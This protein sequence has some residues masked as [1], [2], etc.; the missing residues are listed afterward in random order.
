MNI[1]KHFYLSE[2]CVEA[3]LSEAKKEQRSASRMAEVLIRE[4]IAAR[5]KSGYNAIPVD[6]Q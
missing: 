5:I 4:A 1:Q 3:L 6:V 2:Q